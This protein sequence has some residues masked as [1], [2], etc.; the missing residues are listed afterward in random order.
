MSNNY[1][2]KKTM[3]KTSELTP[4]DVINELIEWIDDNIKEWNKVIYIED[5]IEWLERQKKFYKNN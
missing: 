4:I 2:I 5:I 3:K 1:L